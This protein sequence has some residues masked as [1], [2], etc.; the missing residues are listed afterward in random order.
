MRLSATFIAIGLLALMGTA[1]ARPAEVDNEDA[2]SV[3]ALQEGSFADTDN[4]IMERRSY[5]RPHR[6]RY[7]SFCPDI[8]IIVA[9]APAMMRRSLYRRPHHLCPIFDPIR[10]VPE[11]ATSGLPDLGILGRRAD[12]APVEAASYKSHHHKG[13]RH[14]HSGYGRHYNSYGHRGQYLGVAPLDLG[15]NVEIGRFGGIVVNQG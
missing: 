14:H 5:Y 7:G 6:S 1:Y 2:A 3:D 4:A 12:A 9:P 15:F 10:E 11:V 8:P 13:Y